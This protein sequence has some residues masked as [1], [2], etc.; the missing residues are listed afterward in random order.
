[1]L[2]PP[3][4]QNL[5]IRS[6]R[7]GWGESSSLWEI[8][9]KYKQIEMYF[10]VIGYDGESAKKRLVYLVYD[11]DMNLVV[12]VES[13]SQLTLTYFRKVEEIKE[14]EGK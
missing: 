1:M 6:L 13:G 11:H 4:N 8:G 14:G 2:L 7:K 5:L 12:E 9:P 10:K 3:T